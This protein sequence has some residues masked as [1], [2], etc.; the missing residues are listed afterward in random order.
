MSCSVYATLA[1]ISLGTVI[2]VHA[3]TTPNHTGRFLGIENG[4]LVMAST[5]GTVF[6]IP[7][8]RI[9]VIHIP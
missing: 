8:D 9:S 2:T 6:F 3:G 5:G 4:N 7:I 1:R